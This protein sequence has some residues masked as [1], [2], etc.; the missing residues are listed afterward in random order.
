VNVFLRLTLE[1]TPDE[2]W[3]AIADPAVFTAVSG[4]LMKVTSREKG[5]F[6]TA[7]TAHQ[8]HE[9]SL[10]LLGILPM[11]RQII[12]V[13][14]SE[15]PGGVRMMIDSGT[16][17]SGPLRIVRNWDHRMAVSAADGNKTLYR[18]RLV[19]Q[20]GIFTPVI[21]MGMWMFWQIRGAKLK[22]LARTWN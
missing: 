18:D 13:S 6:P 12:D 10:R 11:G 3:K 4:P 9:V 20:A 15:R 16:P 1:C 19:V 17:Q 2:A 22:K 7:W 8:P 14:F 5:G 21:F